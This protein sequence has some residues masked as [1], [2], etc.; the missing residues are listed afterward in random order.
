MNEMLKN[1]V[2]KFLEYSEMNK[3]KFCKRTDISATTLNSWLR[4]ERD[5]SVRAENRIIDF[6][7]NYTKALVELA[8]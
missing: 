5:I 1:K 6:M 3:T 2:R 8:R 7:Q 4:G